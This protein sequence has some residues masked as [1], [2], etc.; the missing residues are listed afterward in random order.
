MKPDTWNKLDE[1]F[2][3]AP[4]MRATPVVEAEV[5]QAAAAFGLELPADYIQFVCRYGGATV[6]PYSV[7]GLR[8]SDTMGLKESSAFEVTKRFMSQGWRGLEAALIISTDHSGN[9]VYLTS[10]GEV[11]ISDHDFGG[12][13]KL[14]EDFE[15]YLLF[16]CLK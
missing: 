5:V 9:P 12:D 7:Y 14:A 6:G 4:M 16:K 1:M 2:A 15:D 11:W 3:D 13:S 10:S 8:A